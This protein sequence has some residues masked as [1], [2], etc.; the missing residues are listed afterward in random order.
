[1]KRRFSQLAAVIALGAI[2]MFG[3]GGLRAAAAD[4]DFAEGVD[5]L[6][7]GPIHEAFAEPVSY[8]PEPGEVVTKEPPAAVEEI[9]PEE[10]PDGDPLWIP[11]YWHWDDERDD[12]IW[13]SGIWRISPPD[14]SWVPGYWTAVEGG[15]QWTP[16]FWLTNTTEAVE[17]IPEAPPETLEHESP[18]PIATAPAPDY[19]WAPGCWMWLGDRYAWRP[20]Y[21]MQPRAEWV[22]VPP[23]YIRTLHGYIYVE[24]YWDYAVEN[25]GVIFA[26]AYIHRTAWARPGFVFTPSIVIE[27]NII[28]TCLFIGPRHHHYYF[29]DYYSTDY[30]RRGFYP[31]FDYRRHPR[32]Y[33][34]IF[35]HARWSHRDDSNW[36]RRMRDDHD[37]RVRNIDAR[38][39]RRYSDKAVISIRSDNNNR[40]DTRFASKLTDYSKR[41]DSRMRFQK[42]DADQRKSFKDRG[43]EMTRFSSERAR[44]ETKSSRTDHAADRSKEKLTLPTNLRESRKSSVD[45][46][47]RPDSGKSRGGNNGS[48]R[49]GR[50]SDTVRPDT[51]R[52]AVVSGSERRDSGP[53]A[54]P[55]VKPVNTPKLINPRRDSSSRVMPDV[56]PANTPKLINPKRDSISRSDS[57]VKPA[58]TPKLINPR[59][60]A[61]SRIEV[62]PV[63]AP[64]VDTSIKRDSVR[65]TPEVKSRPS[66]DSPSRPDVSSRSRTISDQ[67]RSVKIE[68]SD[69]RKPDSSSSDRR[70]ISSDRGSSSRSDNSKSDSKTSS[71]SSDKGGSSSS[72]S[73]DKAKS[74]PDDHSDRGRGRR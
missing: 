15:W 69:S 43:Q 47:R 46:P 8:N 9:P 55:E 41:T 25:R 28:T 10:K 35:I 6:T 29:G 5:I 60:D 36:D 32:V 39:P 20:G 30:S 22:W 38:P 71:S 63:R 21:W 19:V 11:G 72:S 2:G 23:T 57:D 49:T 59:R 74:T 31:W 48:V 3:M 52:D 73:S 26:P 16:G 45:V 64:K 13:I 66:S 61:S 42:I 33:D 67:S 34:P 70:N 68:S 58:N 4:E 27:T 62:N 1:M 44:V 17:Y 51:K 14:C 24:G 18:P 65:E 7:Q 40:R 53:R 56:K 50:V 54:T 12:F 37:Y